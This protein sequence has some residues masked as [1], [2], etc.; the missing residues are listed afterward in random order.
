MGERQ[1]EGLGLRGV[2]ERAP[3]QVVS[4]EK[5]DLGR[6][7]VGKAVGLIIGRMGRE[8]PIYE[9]RVHVLDV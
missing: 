9:L 1:N 8:I 7:T 5:V 3:L 6:G 2:D 4:L